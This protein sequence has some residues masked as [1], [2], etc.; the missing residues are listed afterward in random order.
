MISK[1]HKSI[2]IKA[3]KAPLWGV[4]GLSIAVLGLGEAGSIFANDLSA[5]GIAVAGWDP[6]PKR[7]LNNKIRFAKNNMD[8]AKDADIIFSVNL[9]SVAEEI[10]A[11]VLPA[12]TAGKIYAEMNTSSPQKKIAVHE[13]LKASG[14]QYVDLAIMAPV[15]PKGIKTPFLISGNGAKLFK[16]KLERYNLNIEVLSET[17]GDAST[18]KLLRSI[19]YKGIAA[20]ICEA[21]EAGK[22]FGLEKYIREQITS[23]IGGND[24]L[25]ERFI[26]GS[27]THAERRI[28][29][30]E[31]VVSMLEGK[32]IKPFMSQAAANNLKKIKKSK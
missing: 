10:A 30:M 32:N 4:G 12:M 24:E 6:D 15:P 25:I 26:E 5:M 19:V 29:E 1:N 16:E 14:V 9:S 23:V 17:V 11:E 18:R 8:A 3:S 20:V 28:Q 13:I 2:S 21:S 22:S 7:E 27:Y 31:A